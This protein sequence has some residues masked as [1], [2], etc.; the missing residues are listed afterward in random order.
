M[1][2]KSVSDVGRST[3]LEDILPK[4]EVGQEGD[5][6]TLEVVGEEAH[7]VRIRLHLDIVGKL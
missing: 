3:V 1:V 4:G 2:N 6:V 5:H 7:G